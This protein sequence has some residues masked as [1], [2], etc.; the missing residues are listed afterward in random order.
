MDA[1]TDTDRDAATAGLIVAGD[2]G[3]YFAI[4]WA[5]LQPY[6]VPTAWV[7]AVAALV[8]GEEPAGDGADV[9]G[10]AGT[11]ALTAAHALL[12]EAIGEMRMARLAAQRLEAWVLLR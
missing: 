5:D 1:T 4:A 11:A 8:R 3:Q 9:R 6:R 10:H 12:V 7:A 2:A